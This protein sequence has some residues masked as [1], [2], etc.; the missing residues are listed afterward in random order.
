MKKILI[1]DDQPDIRELLAE[2]LGANAYEL[3]EAGTGQEAINIAKKEKPHLIIMDIMMPG[4]ING[5]E[6]TNLLKEDPQTNGCHVMILTARGQ[7]VDREKGLKMGADDFIVK[8]F[9]PTELIFKVEE[10]IK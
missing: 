7:T 4:D 10:V 6:A 3:F 9:S 5:Y 2:T 8:P 1:V